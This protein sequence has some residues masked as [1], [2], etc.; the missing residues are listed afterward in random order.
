VPPEVDGQQLED[1]TAVIAA[2]T[3]LSA[4]TG[5]SIVFMYKD[6]DI[7]AIDSGVPD[8]GLAEG[9]LGEWRRALGR[10]RGRGGKAGSNQGTSKDIQNHSRSA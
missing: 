7:G 8:S 6:E 1:A 5:Y 9:F 3:N 4:S 2:M 10:T